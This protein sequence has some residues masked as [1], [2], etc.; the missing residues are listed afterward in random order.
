VTFPRTFATFALAA[1]TLGA[2]SG[3]VA[4][5]VLGAGVRGQSGEELLPDLRQ[6][7]PYELEVR[8]ASK[9]RVVLAFASAVENVGRGALVV[10][11]T[12]R[13]GEDTMRAD[14]LVDLRG[15]SRA[16]RAGIGTLRFVPGGHNHWHFTGFQRFELRNPATGE[17]VARDNKTGFCLG[18]R[19][20]AAPPVAASS[21][22]PVINHNCSRG[23]PGANRLT[24]GITPGFGDDYKA[25]LE[26][27]FV[28][29][30]R[31]PPGRYVLVHRADPERRLA[32]A[33]RADDLASV[34]IQLGRAPAGG[35][36]SVRVLAKCPGR[37]G[38]SAAPCRP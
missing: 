8:R 33:D 36:P 3:S 34:L 21:P 30:T 5:G 29:I 20:P 28:E 10:R 38:T 7:V 24:M 17:R 19:F 9:G 18:D 2:A 32:V 4:L 22:M 13:S 31:V 25:Y 12:R 6:V 23:R 35:V 1:A 37:D 27:Q 14:Q 26:D 11:G 15:G 16:A